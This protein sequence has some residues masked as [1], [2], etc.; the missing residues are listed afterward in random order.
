MADKYTDDEMKTILRG[1]L[2]NIKAELQ[3]GADNPGIS[4]QQLCKAFVV[5]V[6]LVELIMDDHDKG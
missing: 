4:A 2:N 5:L 1:N 6:T 3:Q